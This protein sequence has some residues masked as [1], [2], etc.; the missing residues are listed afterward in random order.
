MMIKI[1]SVGKLK[2]KAF[3]DLVNDYLKRINHYLKCQEIIVSDE[4]EPV[5]ISNKSLEQIKSKEASK[6]FKNINQNDF[7]IA[8]IIE[9]NIIS[10]ETLAKKIQQWLNTFSHDICFIIGGSNG[11]HES[12]YERANYHLSMSKMTFAHGLAK[13]MLCE[14]IYRAL[15][16][17][18]NGKYHK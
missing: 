3:V 11:L 2:Q 8:L 6:I 17:L 1:I 7:V 14:Q 5:Q 16:I 13:V 9:S 4:P 18:N 12:I 15:S 10:S